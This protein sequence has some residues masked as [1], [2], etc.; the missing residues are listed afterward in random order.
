MDHA[1]RSILAE[2]IKRL[3]AQR[4][5]LL[6][7]LEDMFDACEH[8]EDQNDPVLIAARD[9]IAKSKGGE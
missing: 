2:K 4:D 1:L 7:A 3:T 9:A 6:A 8:W 5:E